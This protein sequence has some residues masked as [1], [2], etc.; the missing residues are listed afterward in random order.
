[1]RGRGGKTGGRRRASSADGRRRSGLR[2]VSS[3][4]ITRER[5]RRRGERARVHPPPLRRH[6]HGTAQTDIS[7]WFAMA[8]EDIRVMRMCHRGRH[9]GAAAYHCQQALEKIVKFAVAKYGLMDDPAELNHDI[10]RRLLKK[11]VAEAPPRQ[12]WAADAIRR[13]S[14]LVNEIGRSSRSI[15]GRRGAIQDGNTPTVRDWLWADSLGMPVSNQV[16]DEFRAKINIPP[17]SVLKEFLT[18]HFTNKAKNRI[19]RTVRKV[20]EENGKEAAIQAAYQV[21]VRTMWKEFQRQYKPHAGHKQLSGEEAEACLLLW[22]QANLDTLLK[23]IPHEE[24]GRYPGMWHGKSRTRWY[25]EKSDVLLGLEE[26]V[27]KA[28]YE[29]YRMIKY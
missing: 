28:F 5:A 20:A 19:L 3:A 10:L 23:V 16:L 22:V 24:Y 18:R 12:G 21:C 29:L 27:Y 6:A 15:G 25:N 14:E 11:W 26:S 13:S 9:Y 7:E 8:Q 17:E 1:M 4:A 2:P